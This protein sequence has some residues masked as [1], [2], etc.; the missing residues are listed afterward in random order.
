MKKLLSIALVL[1]MLLSCAW[2]EGGER[3][4]LEVTDYLAAQA[5]IDT[6]LMAEG[7]AGYSFEEPLVVLNPYGNAPLSALAIFTTEE[8]LGGTVTA[9][10]KVSEDDISGTFAPA[11]IHYVPIYGLY[12]GDV[13]QVELTLEDGRSTVLEVETEP[14]DLGLEDYTV[15]M[16]NGELY[17]YSQ[18]T[19]CGNMI[20]RCYAAYDSKGEL[21]WALTGTGANAITLMENGHFLIPTIEGH[22]AEFPNGLTGI[23]EIDPLGKVYNEY[24]WNGGEHHEILEM[25]DGDLMAASSIPGY[26]TDRDY[27]A[28]VD[29]A[30]GEVVWDLDMAQVTAPGASG[31]VN[32]SGRDWSHI[33]SM[34]YDEESDTL[35]I[36]CRHQEAVIAIRKETKELLWILG[37][38]S[39][40]DEEYQEYLLTPVGENFGWPYGQHQ[41]TLMENGDLLLFDNG[42]YGRAKG[43]DQDTAL[44]G[45]ENYSRVV[46]YR[47]DAQNHTVEQVWEYGEELGSKY[48]AGSMSGVQLLDETT[49]SFLVDFGTC[50]SGDRDVT[51][52][53]YLVEGTPIW[54]L[55]YYGSSTY[56]A[57]RYSLYQD[58]TY[59]PSVKGN[60][61]GDMG[62]T[63][64]LEG[65]EANLEDCAAAAEDLSVQL[66]PY[67]A[68][69]IS[70]RLPWEGEEG[71]EEFAVVL[72]AQDGSQRAYDV[73]YTTVNGQDGL[74]L[75]P[76]RWVSLK[77]LPEGNYGIYLVIDGATYDTFCDVEV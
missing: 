2:A 66:Y 65:V 42:E 16:H 8:E 51:Y 55:E 53:Q 50:T 28:E 63:V 60:W 38:P 31:G 67:Q 34:A 9:K 12:A 52:I 64:E 73:A 22:G 13:T 43:P 21:R 72:V 10:G 6:A 17:D 40:W 44:E 32:D 57:Y 37:D 30:T 61:K 75:R 7:E 68:L 24:V 19:V 35:I 56:R 39:G 4:T 18:L 1:V 25:P 46:I 3:A 54:E 36:S 5:E 20:L 47:I 27:L 77:N 58:C 15:Q 29:P 48:Y 71:P 45:S 62:E 41:L 23:R 11:K 70:G 59:D 49:M 74:I 76:S 26:A 14:V 33:N 69:Y